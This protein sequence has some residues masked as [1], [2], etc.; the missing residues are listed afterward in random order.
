MAYVC[1]KDTKES[2]SLIKIFMMKNSI[3]LKSD[4][5]NVYATMS[6]KAKI[7]GKIVLSILIILLV[8]FFVFIT[9]SIELQEFGKAI[10]PLLLFFGILFFFSFRYLVWNLFGK[11]ELIINTKTISYCYDYGVIKTNLKTVH[12]DKLGTGFVSSRVVNGVEFGNLIFY[13]Y[14][15]E[16]NLPDLIHQTSVL[17]DVQRINEI[18]MLIQQVY[19]NEFFEKNNFIGFSIN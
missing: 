19:E 16:D 4:G 14:K 7:I 10:I 8:V 17:I 6:V 2:F 18:N 1:E 12:Y 9:S 13:N 5:I 3:N 11:E 15:K